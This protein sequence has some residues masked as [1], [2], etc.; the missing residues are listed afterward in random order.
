MRI[1]GHVHLW[2]A[3]RGRVSDVLRVAAAA[4]VRRRS[5]L[6]DGRRGRR[7]CRPRPA[8]GPRL[9]PPAA[10]ERARAPPRSLRRFRAGRRRRDES[11][12]AILDDGPG[13]RRA[14]PGRR[15][16]PSRRWRRETR[17]GGRGRRR[18]ARAGARGA[19]RRG[20]LDTAGAGGGGGRRAPRR[21]RPSG[22]SRRSRGRVRLGRCCAPSPATR[23]WS[24]SSRRSTSFRA[25]RFP[26]TDVLPADRRHGRRVRRRTSDVGIQLPVVAAA[27]T[28]APACASS[29][30]S[31][32]QTSPTRRSWERRPAACSSPIGAG[33]WCEWDR[34]RGS[35]SST[36][37]SSWPA[38]WR[39]S[40]WRSGVRG[41]QGRAAGSG[42]RGPPGIRVAV[43]DRGRAQR[44]RRAEPQQAQRDDR[45]QAPGRTGASRSGSASTRTSWSRTSGPA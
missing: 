40:C 27:R 9:R 18:A 16:H 14:R 17:A 4:G 13:G 8:T 21:R 45:S 30:D 34:S 24:S 42:R 25:V 5:P 31:A 10:G 2:D 11:R 32:S 26:T 44:V 28:T 15:A 29:S 35:R 12:Y 37:P 22:S 33:R 43:H 23:T 3:R 38:R 39:R 7:A 1:D 20:V 6:A 36:S 19:R 41:H